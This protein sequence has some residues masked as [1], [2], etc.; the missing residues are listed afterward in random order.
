[1]FQNIMC[2]S[3]VF[4]MKNQQSKNQVF[5]FKK[6]QLLQLLQITYIQ[7]AFFISLTM[8]DENFGI[9][10]NIDRTFTVNHEDKIE[11]DSM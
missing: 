1:M 2:K 6:C 5:G 7:P 10:L 11:L 8:T 3:K 4:S 9:L